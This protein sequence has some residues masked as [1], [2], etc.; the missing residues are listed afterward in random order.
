MG[1]GIGVDSRSWKSKEA[2]FHLKASKRMQ[3]FP[4]L[5]F[6]QL[7]PRLLASETVR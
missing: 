2:D 4:H 3:S 7:R 1:Q 5:D 6:S